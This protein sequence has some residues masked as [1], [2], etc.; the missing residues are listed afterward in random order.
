[1]TW[2]EVIND[3]QWVGG[4]FETHRQGQVFRGRIRQVVLEGPVVRVYACWVARLSIGRGRR[5]KSINW[6]TDQPYA[7]YLTDLFTPEVKEDG[8]VKVVGPDGLGAPEILFPKGVSHL[9]P[10]FVKG[11]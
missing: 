1:M 5:W 8:S 4:D 10:K 6:S 3:K 2:D 9:D 11:L 7:E